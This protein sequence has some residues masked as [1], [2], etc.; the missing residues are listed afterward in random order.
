MLLKYG[1]EIDPI[2]GDMKMPI[3]YVDKLETKT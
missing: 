1:A 2:D 3:N